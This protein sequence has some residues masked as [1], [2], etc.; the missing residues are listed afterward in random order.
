MTITS[1]NSILIAMVLS[2]FSIMGFSSGI[3]Q[4]AKRKSKKYRW[5]IS[6]IVNIQTCS[7]KKLT[8]LPGI[9]S[10][11]AVRIINY[12]KKHK[13]QRLTDIKRVKGIGKKMF[14]KIKQ[15]LTLTGT[16]TI[17]RVRIRVN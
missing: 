5:K 10:K 14:A 17:K 15:Y 3:A 4:G 12:R 9:G 13:F 16:T 7:A 6:G 8:Y 1:K 11:K 2:I